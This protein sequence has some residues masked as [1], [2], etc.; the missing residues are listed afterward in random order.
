M[1]N[2]IVLMEATKQIVL[3]ALKNAL[4]SVI[5]TNIAGTA[6]RFRLVFQTKVNRLRIA[7]NNETYCYAQ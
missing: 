3:I 7:V 2:Q 4:I 6:L 5:A 1:A